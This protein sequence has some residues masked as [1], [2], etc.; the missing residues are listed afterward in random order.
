MLCEHQNSLERSSHPQ[1]VGMEHSSESLVLAHGALTYVFVHELALV[2][3]VQVDE[4]SGTLL[5]SMN[6]G[7][8]I[9]TAGLCVEVGA[10]PVPGKDKTRVLGHCPGWRTDPRGRPAHRRCVSTQRLSMPP[11]HGALRE[12]WDQHPLT[13]QGQLLHTNCFPREDVG[14]LD[15]H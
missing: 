5:L 15:L 6:P 13:R 11:T 8:D 2:P 4:L 1:L 10:L 3:V 12:S 14:L 9:L 7:T